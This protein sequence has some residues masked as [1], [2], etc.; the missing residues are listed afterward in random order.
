[1]NQDINIIIQHRLGRQDA[2][3]AKPHSGHSVTTN[4][5]TDLTT[6]STLP[7]TTHFVARIK[8]FKIHD[9]NLLDPEIV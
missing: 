2:V 9:D 3:N 6:I 5:T 8:R 4:C 7:L 1:M